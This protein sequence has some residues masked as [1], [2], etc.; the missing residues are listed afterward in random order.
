MELIG[1][2]FGRLTVIGRG[3]DHIYKSGRKERVWICQCSC[4]DRTIREIMECNLKRN[5]R[6]TRSC[7]CI[8]RENTATRSKKYNRYDLSGEYGVGYTS[9]TNTHFYF[10]IEDYEII[11]KYCWREEVKGYIR[12]TAIINNE[13]VSVWLHRLVMNAQPGEL[14]DHIKHKKY[15]NRKSQM[16]IVNNSQNIM[17]SK[18]NNKNTSGVPGVHQR[19]DSKKWVARIT[20]NGERLYLGTFLNFQDAVAARRQAED[21]YFKEFSYT[22]SMQMELDCQ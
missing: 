13:E 12:A 7:G 4:K 3:E 16:R 21:V 19:K 17:N 14:V 11:K 5:D 20:I 15:D 22:N 9:N 2:V 18:P 6:P 10:D 8:T 1:Q